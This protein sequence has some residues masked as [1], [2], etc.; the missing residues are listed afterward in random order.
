M[1]F[2]TYGNVNVHVGNIELYQ[3]QFTF[4]KRKV[5]QVLLNEQPFVNYP[6]TDWVQNF[7]LAN[8]PFSIDNTLCDEQGDAT[9]KIETGLA[10]TL[11]DWCMLNVNRQLKLQNIFLSNSRIF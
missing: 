9:V 3:N 7:T 4:S 2:V 5:N 1:K 6:I 10:S 8:D 11:N